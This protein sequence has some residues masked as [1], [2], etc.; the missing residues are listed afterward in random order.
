M[1]PTELASPVQPSA[2]VVKS[3]VSAQLA[4]ILSENSNKTV[5]A[6]LV[7]MMM[8]QPNAK[9][10]TL[11]VRP[12]P[13]QHLVHHVSVKTTEPS[14]TDNVFAHQV[15]IKSLTLTTPSLVRNAVLNAKNATDPTSVWT[16]MPHKIE[17]SVMMNLVIKLA[18]AFQ[19]SALPRTAH[20]SKTVVLLILTAKF[21]TMLETLP[22]VPNV[23]AQLIESWLFLNTSVFVSK[24]S[25]T[26]QEF[27]SHAHQ[28]VLSALMPPFVSDAPFQ[29]PATTMELVPAHK[30]TFLQLNP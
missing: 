8:V 27:A 18:S 16:V 26:N 2:T 3:T 6:Q 23:L 4:Q 21:V 25:L 20:V 14:T 7:S 11:F 9:L 30:V 12:A 15:S 19:D 10:A 1:N 17:S 22:S 29:P 13:T 28:A 5:I 24:V